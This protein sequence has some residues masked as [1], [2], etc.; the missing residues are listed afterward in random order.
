MAGLSSS[1][2]NFSKLYY[3]LECITGGDL[4]RLKTVVGGDQMTRVNL[5][6]AKNLRRGCFTQ[7]E[8]LE[9]L[10]PII[11]EMFHTL[12]DFLEVDCYTPILNKPIELLIA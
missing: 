7:A 6:S 9:H 10:H 1:F 2:I 12:M 11:V 3:S 4:E 5:Q 8:R